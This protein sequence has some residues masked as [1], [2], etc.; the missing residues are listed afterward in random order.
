MIENLTSHLRDHSVER[1]EKS[2]K[3]LQADLSLWRRNRFLI[4]NYGPSPSRLRA[5]RNITIS[6]SAWITPRKEDTQPPRIFPA[7][8]A[9]LSN[10]G[11]YRAER[12][13]SAK[14]DQNA[15]KGMGSPDDRRNRGVTTSGGVTGD[16]QREDG[17]SQDTI[18]TKVIEDA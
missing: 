9:G 18:T 11:L 4:M 13:G 3:S 2:F 16:I 5:F 10:P 12:N 8:K 6:K 14:E 1:N 7:A 15:S 17:G